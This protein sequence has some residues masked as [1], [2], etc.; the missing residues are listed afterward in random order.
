M[1][2]VSKLASQ[3]GRNDDEPNKELGKAL[4][5]QHDV[6]GIRDIVAHLSDADK[7]IQA[8]CLS[9]LEQVGR[10]APELIADYVSD[11]LQLVQSKNNRLVWAAMIDL[12]LIADRKPQEIFERYDEI[13]QVMVDG[14]VITQDNGIKILAR[15]ASTST[16]YHK[17]IWPFLLEQLSSCRAKSVP[18]YAESISVAVNPECQDQYQDILKKRYEIL[19]TAQRKRVKKL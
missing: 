9:V 19:S 7:R 2:I 6:G 18:Q 1:S 17:T 16:E 13:V 11:F 4:V 14:S 10:L 15:V 12:A 3:Q 8:D 5:A